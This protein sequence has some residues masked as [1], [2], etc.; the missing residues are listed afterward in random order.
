MENGKLTKPGPIRIGF[1]YQDAHAINLFIEWAAHPNRYVW[2]KLESEE[3]GFLDDVIML[4]KDNILH[5]KQIKYSVHPEVPEESWSWNHLLERRKGERGAK[6]SF[7]KKWFISWHDLAKEQT[8]SKI[9]P[10]FYTNRKAGLDLLESTSFSSEGYGRII[11]YEKV[12][13]KFKPHFEEMLSQISPLSENELRGFLN[14]FHLHFDEPDLNDVRQNAKKRFEALGGNEEGWLSLKESVRTWATMRDLP[15]LGGTITIEALRKAA[16]WLEPK[17]LNQEFVVPDDFF[18]FDDHI[19][20]QLLSDLKQ[21]SGGVRVLVGSPGIGKST[22]LSHLY[23]ELKNQNWPVIRH[24][25]FVSIKDPKFSDR[26]DHRRAW[27]SLIHDILFEHKESLEEDSARNPGDLPLRDLLT[28][29][30][31]YYRQNGKSLVLIIDGLDHVARYSSI[32]E[33]HDFLSEVVPATDGLWVVF[34]TQPMEERNFPPTF[35]N[36]SPRK[37]W[38]EVHSLSE[39]GVT[40]IVNSNSERIKLPDSQY[41]EDEIVSTFIKITEGHPL[42]LRYSIDFIAN[43]IGDGFLTAYELENLPPYGGNITFYYEELWRRS[44]EEGQR[45]AILLALAEFPLRQEHLIQCLDPLGT[46][47]VQLMKGFK[48]ISHLITQTSEGLL[49]FHPS[50]VPFVENTPQ[51]KGFSAQMKKNLKE[52][53]ENFAP[54]HIR[55]AHLTRLEYELGNPDPLINSLNREWIIEALIKSRPFYR[56][57]EQLRLGVDAAMHKEDLPRALEIGLLLFYVERI[58]DEMTE[59]FNKLWSLCL[60]N[61][62]EAPLS[63]LP[64]LSTPQLLTLSRLAE[65]SGRKEIGGIIV[66]IL[67]RRQKQNQPRMKGEISDPWWPDAMALAKAV[68]Y[69]R[70]STS[71]LIKYAIQ[72][73][74][75]YRTSDLISAYGEALAETSQFTT[76]E[77]L[78]LSGDLQTNEKLEILEVCAKWAFKKKQDIIKVI[79]LQPE[80]GWGPLTWVYLCINKQVPNDRIPK[81]L[82]YD[83]FPLTVKEY[84]TAERMLNAE[85]FLTCYLSSLSLTLL[86]HENI[87]ENWIKD[88]KD[89]RWSLQVADLLCELGVDTAKQLMEKRSYDYIGFVNKVD[90]LPQPT[91]AKDKEIIEL[92][93]AFQIAIQNIFRI[94]FLLNGWYNEKVSIDLETVQKYS[95]SPFFG[96]SRFIESIISLSEPTL[97]QEAYLRFIAKEEDRLRTEIT[98]FSTRAER[99]VDLALLAKIHSDQVGCQRLLKKAATNMIAYGYH[100]DLFLLLVLESIEACHDANSKKGAMWLTRIASLIEEVENYTDGDETN[101]LPKAIA[102]SLSKINPERLMAYYCD[103]ATK[104]RLFLA[105]DVFHHLVSSFKFE[106]AVEASLAKTAV[107]FD[108]ISALKASASSG[109]KIAQSVINEN[110]EYFGNLESFDPEK[111]KPTSYAAMPKEHDETDLLKVPPNGLKEKLLSIKTHYERNK[112]LLIWFSTWVTQPRFRREVYESTSDWINLIG[113][114]KVEFKILDLLYPLAIEF[115]GKEKGF[116]LLCEANIEG[117]GWSRF[118]SDKNAITKRW[119]FLKANFPSRTKEF[120]KRSLEKT[121]LGKRYSFF[122]PIPLG[123]EFLLYFGSIEEAESLTEAGVRFAESLMADLE[124]PTP[125]WVNMSPPD[126][127]DILFIRLVWPSP[128][129]RER[130]A[131]AISDLLLDQNTSKIASKKMTAWV[132]AQKLESLVVIGLLPILRAARKSRSQFPLDYNTIEKAVSRPSVVSGSLLKELHDALKKENRHTE[133]SNILDP[134]G[135]LK[136]PSDYKASKFFIEFVQGFLAPGYWDRATEIE[137]KWGSGFINQWSWES[138]NLAEEIGLKELYG[139]CMSF[140]GGNHRPVLLG[141][142]TMMSE[143]FRSAF[144]RALASY[145]KGGRIPIDFFLDYSFSTCPIDITFWEVMPQKSPEWWPAMGEKLS[146]EIDTSKGRIWSAIEETVNNLGFAGNPKTGF[147]ILAAQGPMKPRGGWF[148]EELDTE[149]IT[150][151]FAYEVKGPAI[152]DPEKV[153]RDLFYKPVWFSNPRSSNPLCFFESEKLCTVDTGG[154]RVGDMT[155]Y[156][157]TARLHPISI[158]LWQWFRDRYAPW[159]LSPNLTSQGV[160]LIHKTSCWVYNLEGKEV[161]TSY[162]WLSG[163][164]ERHA[165][166]SAIPCGQV[167]EVDGDW[168]TNILSNQELRLGYLVKIKSML[169]KYSYEKARKF[170]ETRFFGV[171]SIIL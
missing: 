121:R 45:L 91:W 31:Q 30:S 12:K 108:S 140:L 101:H 54:E 55:W 19:H 170:E 71:A 27:E 13:N 93:H 103:L 70:F 4:D 62:D 58:P 38:I 36:A 87:V 145:G 159:G 37:D 142:S 65:S 11:N 69:F 157:L 57:E 64:D 9:M 100:K 152:P 80:E 16:K 82:D 124:L 130:A 5:V 42:H 24:H 66:D 118:F 63:L 7:F 25:Y 48:Q 50:F 156:P 133:S 163:I 17:G 151:G 135:L 51:Y 32:D 33:L 149:F 125:S 134:V 106:S 112:F 98:Y 94:N 119:E 131:V 111:E 132:A 67:N 160:S 114:E 138:H 161:A 155:I 139:E 20:Q 52:W 23:K 104:E 39:D 122:M 169:K 43:N 96:T 117:Y 129:I 90:C 68:A 167:L 79:Q 41:A 116:D 95:D 86:G 40:H 105:Q 84:L 109:N 107:D 153:C 137:R 60:Q 61:I 115:E 28:K 21:P 18:L 2:A 10:S 168:L 171:S 165:K 128:L 8:F 35:F 97:G 146:G 83:Q 99:Y 22:Y 46:Q 150:V 72:F 89:S 164:I 29:S 88:S 77:G 85:K 76:L 49:P 141:M 102:K 144:I 123:V 92:L 75:L 73:R 136:C 166:D 53:V 59:P 44:P 56:I 34:G 81:L 120:M 126:H 26:L 47:S 127:W 6:P 143:V 78:L 110:K 147:K 158:N 148:S 14:V 3:S 162:D 15:T 74:D 113:I 154:F 1:D